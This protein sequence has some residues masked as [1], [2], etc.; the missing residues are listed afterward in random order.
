MISHFMLLCTAGHETTAATAAMGMWQLARRPGVLEDL[1]RRPEFIPSFVEET[2]RWATPVQHFIRSAA[3]DC[4]LNEQKIRAGDLLYLSYLSANFDEQAF[5]N[6]FEFDHLRV[7]NRHLSF[8][9][10]DH[11]CL[12]IGFA[13][14]SL[15]ALWNAIIPGVRNLSVSGDLRMSM[16]T[17]VSGPKTVPVAFEIR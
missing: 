8:S 2:I 6:P 11:V 17:F 7:P 12:G 15:I 1:Q 13:R 4:C 5:T 14:A 9:A 3:K 10:G 16:S